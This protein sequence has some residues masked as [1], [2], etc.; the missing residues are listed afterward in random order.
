MLDIFSNIHRHFIFHLHFYN[1]T[2]G[3]KIRN[4]SRL[5]KHFNFYTIIN[6]KSL[7][8]TNVLIWQ[9]L[10]SSISKRPK[11][12]SLHFPPLLKLKLVLLLIAKVPSW[13]I[14]H[15]QWNKEQTL[16]FWL[17]SR[18]ND[19]AQCYKPLMC[20][21]IAIHIW[22]KVSEKKYYQLHSINQKFKP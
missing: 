20:L 21:L 13:C 7:N 16:K 11:S 22:A 10:C 12:N 17:L 8:I 18:G 14:E 9:K 15:C 19:N 3:F 6:K 4:L 2:F 5:S 1:D